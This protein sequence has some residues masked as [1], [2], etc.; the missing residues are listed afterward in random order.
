MDGIRFFDGIQDIAHI[1]SCNIGS[2]HFEGNSFSKVNQSWNNQTGK[3]GECSCT[4]E[5]YHGSTGN[6]TGGFNTSDA[7]DPHD[8]GTEYKWKDHHIQG[9]HVDAAE[10]TGNCQNRCKTVCK[11]QSGQDTEKQADKDRTGNMLLIPGIKFF[12]FFSSSKKW[13]VWQKSS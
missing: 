11:K 7:A 1:C 8:N 6:L 5:K 2:G 10:K 3:A 12:H 4:K 13:Y 9:I